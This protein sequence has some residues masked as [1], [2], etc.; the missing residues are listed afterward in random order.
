MLKRIDKPEENTRRYYDRYWNLVVKEH[1]SSEF[2]LETLPNGDH[3]SYVL[4]ANAMRIIEH[5]QFHHNYNPH[6][7]KCIVDDSYE[8]LR[9]EPVQDLHYFVYNLDGSSITSKE[10][11][12]AQIENMLATWTIPPAHIINSSTVNKSLTREIIE[13]T[14]KSAK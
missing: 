4:M 5:L 12:L 8:M 14:S 9:G 13:R 6:K 10:E 2:Y 1:K 3:H 7:H 11:T